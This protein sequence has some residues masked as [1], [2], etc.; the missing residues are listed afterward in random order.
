MNE[1][2]GLFNLKDKLV[3][4]TGGQGDLGSEYAR[5]LVLAGAKVAIFDVSKKI[6]PKIEKLMGQGHEI[7]NFCLDI[8]NKKAVQMAFA[9]LIKQFNDTP[10]ILINNAGLSSHPSG[11]ADENG[12]FEK[13]PEEVWDA[14]LDSHL[15]GMFLVS[16]VFIEK[17]REA[18]KKEGSIINISSIYGVVSPEQSLYDFR[19]K[20]GEKYYK[21]IGY[22]V[23]KSGVLNF[24]R[25]LAEYCAYEKL[26]LRVNTLVLGGVYAGQDHMF[27]KEYEKRTMLKR[28]A[29]NQD[30]NGAVLFLASKAS[31]YMTGSTITIDGGWTAR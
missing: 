17:Y 3:L 4:I 20:Q 5:A 10:T 14:M 23:A 16:Q 12:P 30:F 31:A 18:E 25:W 22:S 15:K 28:M 24:T 8:T 2:D 19:R 6:N 13:Y 11:S 21:P 7:K 27:V 1:I 26:G 29:T 9:K